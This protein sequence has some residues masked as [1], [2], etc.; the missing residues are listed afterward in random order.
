[1][2]NELLNVITYDKETGIFCWN[3][4]ASPRM[5]GKNAGTIDKEGYVIIG[6]NKK[7]YKAHRLAWLISFGEFPKNEIDHIDGNKQNNRIENLRDVS[8]S[9]NQSNII[10]PQSV[11]KLGLRGVCKHRNK[12]M[13]DI[14]VN[15]KKIYLGVFDTAELAQSAYLQAKNKYHA[16]AIEAKLKEKNGF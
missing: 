10:Q 14:K 7:K 9:I 13:A 3:E 2:I 16:R 11:N 1:M 15:G 12:F 6:F 4:S 5:I 8:R